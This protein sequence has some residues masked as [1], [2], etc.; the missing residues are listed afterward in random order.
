MAIFDIVVFV[1]A[2]IAVINGW[3]RGFVVQAFGLAAIIL[4][5]FVAIRTGA[6]AGAKLHIDP[7]YATAAGFLLIF[8]CVVG[9]LLLIGHLIRKLFKTAGLGLFDVLFGIILSLIKVALVLGILCTI[10]DKLNDGAK[11]VPQSSLDRSITYRPLCNVIEVFGV[12]SK[13]AGDQTE[14]IVDKALDTI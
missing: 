1:I 11:F 5:I 9:A 6:E 4:G 8:V 14:K 12:W 2:A 13:A 10:F 3:R 7:R